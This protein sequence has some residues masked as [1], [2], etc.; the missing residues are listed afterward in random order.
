MP[1]MTPMMSA[2]RRDASWM[3]FMVCTTWP[4]T[5]PPFTATPLAPS[6]S[7]FACRALSA[8]CLTVALSCSSDA[9]VSS[10]ADACCS[11]R[12]DRSLLPAAICA[13]AVARL[14]AFWRTAVTTLA[15]LACIS[16]SRAIRLLPSPRAGS[17]RVARSPAATRWASARGVP[18]LG[19]ELA[20]DG[21]RQV[22]AEQQCKQ[23]A[24]G[25]GCQGRA[26]HQGSAGGRGGVCLARPVH[27]QADQRA[28][29]LLGGGGQRAQALEF[30]ALC[31]LQVAGAQR[32]Q[33]R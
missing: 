5:S 32:L 16:C 22:R 26:A 20:P 12:S 4:T 30:E 29:A 31:F 14:S 6:A 28:Q 17:M 9:A 2:M 3:P 21:A 18:R 25:H 1:S 24:A 11:V 13:E 15:R 33:R 7:W 23:H 27:A 19:A 10:S 8:F